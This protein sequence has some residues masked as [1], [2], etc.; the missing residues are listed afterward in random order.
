MPTAWLQHGPGALVLSHGRGD[1][2]PCRQL[3]P[4]HPPCAGLCDLASVSPTVR[5][6]SKGLRRTPPPVSTNVRWKPSLIA[7]RGVHHC[8]PLHLERASGVCRSC[9]SGWTHPED[10]PVVPVFD[11][12]AHARFSLRHWQVMQEQ[13]ATPADLARAAEGVAVWSARVATLARLSTP[14]ASEPGSTPAVCNTSFRIAT[15][16]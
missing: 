9:A 2:W 12:V 5:S 4:S 13:A 8:A 6:F 7:R 10:H 11:A 16:P 14:I 15:S 1:A 3:Y